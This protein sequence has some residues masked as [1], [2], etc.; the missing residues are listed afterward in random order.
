MEFSSLCEGFD[1]LRAKEKFTPEA[2]VDSLFESLQKLYGSKGTGFSPYI[3]AKNGWALAPE[4][5]F[6][7]LYS[8]RG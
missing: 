6:W 4:G 1:S 5:G 2:V 7:S 8:L 3:S